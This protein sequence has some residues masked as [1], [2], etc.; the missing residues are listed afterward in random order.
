MAVR[1]GKEP[2]TSMYFPKEEYE[3]RWR[4]V[5]DEMDARGFD[6]AVI[7]GRSAGTYERCGNVLY[8]T[9]YYSYQSGHEEDTNM[10]MGISFSAAIMSN[11]EA[12]TLVADMADFPSHL[13]PL[14]DYV[15]EPNVILAVA[16]AI[17]NRGLKGRVALVGTDFLPVKYFN[18]LKEELQEVEFVAADDLLVNVRRRKSPR[19]L[20]CYREAGD[21]ASAALTAQMEKV[22]QGGVSQSEAA[23]AGAAEVIRRGGFPHMVPVSSGKGIYQFYGDH[24]TGSSSQVVLNEGDMVRTWIYGPMWQGYWL[25]PGRTAVVGRKPSAEQRDF[26]EKGAAIID[27]LIQEIRPNRKVADIVGLGIDMRR[28]T[29]TED[30]QPG[31]MWPLFG[32]GVGLFWEPPWLLK[33]AADENNPDVFYEGDVL[34][35]EVFLYWP[36]LGSLGIEQNIIVGREE[37]E[38]LTTTDMF[39]W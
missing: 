5:Y 2:T 32:H 16:K 12:P 37:N 6:A 21:R 39:W 15:W 33:S 29:G 22:V 28:E 11:R 24:I 1:V 34:G 14:D 9:N 7:W 27:R 38:L 19:E 3:E 10:W 18:V 13:L 23:A 31:K 30:D 20:D 8:L 26:I 35:V 25:D 4:R 17:R 36:H